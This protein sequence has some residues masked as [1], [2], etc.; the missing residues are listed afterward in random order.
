MNT[1]KESI[2]DNKPVRHE[3]KGS[4]AVTY[5]YRYKHEDFWRTRLFTKDGAEFDAFGSTQAQSR[6]HAIKKA[7]M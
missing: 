1:S 5:S 7:G 2:F 4:G 3:H 6:I